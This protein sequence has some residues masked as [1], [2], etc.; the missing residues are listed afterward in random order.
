MDKEKKCSCGGDLD[1]LATYAGESWNYRSA[2]F[3]YIAG[4]QDAR[5]GTVGTL[6]T[7]Q[8]AGGIVIDSGLPDVKSFSFTWQGELRQLLVK[9]NS[10]GGVIPS[11]C[12]IRLVKPRTNGKWESLSGDVTI[13]DWNETPFAPLLF[14]PRALAEWGDLLYLIDYE[15]QRIVILGADE[16][17]GMSG[18]YE[19]IKTPFSF[20]NAQVPTAGK[21]QAL[22]IIGDKLYALYLSTNAQ[23]GGHGYGI[24]CRL[25]IGSNGTLTFDTLVNVGLNPQAIIPVSDGE[26]IQLLIPAIGG[27]QHPD[28]TT[29][30][31][32]SNICCVPAVGPWNYDPDEGVPVLITGDEYPPVQPDSKSEDPDPPPAAP[33]AYDIH[34]VAAGTRGR[35]NMLYILTQLYMDL[36]NPNEDEKALW[37][38]YK[39][40]VGQF[41]DLAS[42]DDA[43]LS[44]TGALG[45]GL[46]AL[47]EGV[48][49]SIVTGGIY[50]WD[51]LYAQTAEVSDAGDL[52][53]MALGTPIL[54]TRAAEGGYGAPD[55]EDENAYVVFGFNGGNNVNAIDLPI[56]AINDA[57]RGGL[58]LKRGLYGYV[59]SS[60]SSESS[61]S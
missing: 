15:T 60:G 25:D 18:N 39:I 6:V 9:I 54:V 29:N 7:P 17:E 31:T 10:E 46:E 44:L 27:I 12:T 28:G 53:W 51:L 34:A 1:I 2:R 20:T 13:G 21:G 47:D 45:H 11:S 24:L 16:L 3:M 37:K 35:S 33:T 4:K 26:N 8:Q 14:N 38:L 59:I 43:P 41:L 49:T 19:P 5:P 50:F 48:V 52:L 23:A 42:A 56:A 32:E 57:R 58:S 30:G 40:K 22:V 55:S 61:G 36:D